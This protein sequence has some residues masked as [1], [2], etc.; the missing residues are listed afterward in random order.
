M[1]MLTNTWQSCFVFEQSSKK[2][3]TAGKA[4]CKA[5]VV[6]NDWMWR[7]ALLRAQAERYHW[8]A[9]IQK[10][11]HWCVYSTSLSWSPLSLAYITLVRNFPKKKKRVFN[12]NRRIISLSSFVMIN[13]NSSGLMISFSHFIWIHLFFAFN[14]KTLETYSLVFFWQLSDMLQ[15]LHWSTAYTYIQQHIEESTRPST[16]WDGRLVIIS[17]GPERHG[18]IV[19]C[20]ISRRDFSMI[21][22]ERERARLRS[23]SAIASDLN[24]E[25]WSAFIRSSLSYWTASRIEDVCFGSPLRSPTYTS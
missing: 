21:A 9:I 8:S 18:K 3:S 2:P 23:N 10:K 13:W 22:G 14:F 6:V 19:L 12:W 11:K 1:R 5:L 16:H 25:K 20:G 4:T 17:V 15:K 24:P 7:I